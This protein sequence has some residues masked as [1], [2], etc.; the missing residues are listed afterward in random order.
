MLLKLR[1]NK[2]Y[3]NFY[4][5]HAI[6]C[7]C[8]LVFDFLFFCNFSYSEKSEPEV[9]VIND[10][11]TKTLFYESSEMT[12]IKNVMQGNLDLDSDIEIGILG[13]LSMHAIDPISGTRKFNIK[14]RWT[15]G[16]LR[17]E[18]IYSNK[19][20]HYKVMSGGHVSDVGLMNHLGEPIWIY[21][22][23]SGVLINTMAAGDLDRNGELEFYVATHRGLHQLN[24]LGEKLWEKG[25]WVF[26]VDV[27]DHR[28]A[29]IPLVVTI[30]S[31]GQIQFRN[32]EGELVREVKPQI[33]IN[34]IEFIEW[35]NPGHILTRAGSSIF[36]LNSEGKVV[37]SHKLKQ[38]IYAI[39]G[40][41]VQFIVNQKPYLAVIAKF[42]ST[43]GKAMLCIFSP[44][45][46]L[47]YEELVKTTLGLLATKSQSSGGEML[48]V[49]NGPGRV[50]KYDGLKR[51]VK[52][53][54][55]GTSVI[56]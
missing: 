21:K 28:K 45:G 11:I 30:C 1:T 6:L 29:K 17:P 19:D 44:D 48:L 27:F 34:N 46:K 50:Y 25:S 37:F 53:S 33:K 22:P 18:V 47:A 36:I 7:C 3:D 43:T 10:F 2:R 8:I 56:K 42:S 32:Y 20:K 16:I 13:Q 9:I 51:D 35:P 31:D 12:A 5:K 14:F 38:H 49:G 52:E 41:S 54:K 15:S 39:R 40:T 26:D 55:R 23:A 24:V 4:I